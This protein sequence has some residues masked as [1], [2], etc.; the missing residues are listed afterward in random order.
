MTP[1]P[2]YISKT[3]L[4]L[5]AVLVPLQQSFAANCC[6]RQGSGSAMRRANEPG[7]SCCSQKTSSCCS[8]DAVTT[9]SCCTPQ[10]DTEANHCH[11]PA[12]SCGQ[13]DPTAAEPPATSEVPDGNEL[14][15]MTLASPA[16]RESKLSLTT[17]L[18]TATATKSLGS[19]DRCVLLCRFTL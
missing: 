17:K 6:C 19:T 1:S 3:L 4:L 11:C 14:V 16:A 8:S 2:R 18:L 5:A 10:Q 9:A 7:M 15:Q 12:G 13:D